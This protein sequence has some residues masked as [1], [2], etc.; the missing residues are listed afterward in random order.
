MTDA[1]ASDL[2]A[3][4]PLEIWPFLNHPDYLKSHGCLLPWITV[5]LDR[6]AS[7]FQF[8]FEGP[9]IS[10]DCLDYSM[11]TISNGSMSWPKDFLLAQDLFHVRG[12]PPGRGHE[13]TSAQQTH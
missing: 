3:L 11:R 8:C 1:A 10:V 13:T 5:S 2:L 6:H 9:E 4:E 7:V 12:F